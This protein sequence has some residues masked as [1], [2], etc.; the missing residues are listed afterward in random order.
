MTVK[1]KSGYLFSEWTIAWFLFYALVIAAT[2]GM[3]ET[4]KT[5]TDYLNNSLILLIVTGVL[6]GPF[7]IQKWL[8][9]YRSNQRTF[10]NGGHR[11]EKLNA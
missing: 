2:V 11:I 3:M 5:A 9:I 4:P 7:A 8:R 1:Q 10:E 6:L